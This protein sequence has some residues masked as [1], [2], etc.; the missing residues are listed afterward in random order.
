MNFRSHSGIVQC[1]TA[2]LDKLIACF[3]YS[4]DR[5]PERGLIKGPNPLWYQPKPIHT[6]DE[7]SKQLMI[8]EN[9][10]TLI[11]NNNRYFVICQNG[12]NEEVLQKYNAIQPASLLT[13]T[14]SKGLEF[15]DV[16]ILDFF[17][18]LPASDQKQWSEIFKNENFDGGVDHFHGQI[19]TQ[20]KML[21]TAITRCRSR[22][23]VYHHHYY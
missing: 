1:A 21:Y 15:E 9:V 2:V 8:I 20:L 10:N 7:Q 19:E 22:F 5:I 13:I 11:N 17:S 14:E 16:I 12:R 23:V 4:V 18:H 3:P 6:V